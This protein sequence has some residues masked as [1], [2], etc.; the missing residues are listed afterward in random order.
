MKQE[1]EF[2]EYSLSVVC[3]YLICLSILVFLF[4]ALRLLFLLLGVSSVGCTVIS[5]C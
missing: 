3:T 4:C 2:L 1:I 5:V